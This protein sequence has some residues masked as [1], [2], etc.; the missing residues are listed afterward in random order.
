[1][2]HKFTFLL[3]LMLVFSQNNYAQCPSP[4]NL[5]TP[6]NQ[7]NGQRGVM[8]DVDAINTITI[9]CFD[10]SLYA[11]TTA[12]YEI[13]YKVGTHQGF[14]NN[15]AAWTF[16]G[17]ANAVTSNGSGVPTN[18]PIAVNVT[19]PAGQT[20][21]FYVTN[22]SGGGLNYTDGSNYA[23]VIASNADLRTYEGTGKS[24]PFGLSFV[25]RS[26]NGHIHYT[27]GILLPVEYLNFEGKAVAENN[28]LQWTTATETETQHFEVQRSKDGVNYET[29]GVVDAAG[30]SETSKNYSFED[31]RFY[32]RT[33]Y[34]LKLVD[35]TGEFEYSKVIMVEGTMPET[36]SVYPNPTSG[37][38]NI[39]SPYAS[40]FF[41]MDIL[42]HRL[43]SI[44]FQQQDSQ[45]IDISELPNGVYYLVDEQMGKN[46]KVIKTN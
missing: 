8:F 43:K 10:A 22:T 46:I 36:L 35:N 41:I 1:M 25:T 7:N 12:N 39:S 42:G 21:A 23:N 20:Y 19:I 17:A 40:R 37:I 34:R 33:Y 29:V 5:A 28:L 30:N 24:Y 9:T 4:T 16:V 45:S 11:G 31:P 14:Q 27:N 6:Y 15:S 13:Y 3:L 32:Q 18:I 44:N 38:L 26:F 2:L